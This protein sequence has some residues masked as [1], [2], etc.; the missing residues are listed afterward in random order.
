[1]KRRTRVT[2]WIVA[3]WGIIAIPTLLRMTSFI[4]KYPFINAVVLVWLILWV[5][6]LLRQPWARNALLI[7][8]AAQFATSVYY[9]VGPQQHP[10]IGVSLVGFAMQGW[11]VFVLLTENPHEWGKEFTHD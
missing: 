8:L 3:I 2:A 4:A 9:I 10:S 11:Q 6:V 5:C 7:V 1:M